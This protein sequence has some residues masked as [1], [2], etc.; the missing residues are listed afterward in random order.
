MRGYAFEVADDVQE[1]ALVSIVSGRPSRRRCR[2]SSSAFLG[3][4]AHQHLFVKQ[5]ARLAFVARHEDSHRHAELPQHALLHLVY[6]RAPFRANRSLFLIL[7][8]ASSRELYVKRVADVL[9]VDG[10]TQDFR[11]PPQVRFLEPIITA[12]LDVMPLTA[13]WR[14]LI[15]SSRAATC[16]ASCGRPTRARPRTPAACL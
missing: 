5:V 10:E 14:R 13:L 7:R 2:W 4:I 12:N 8:A 9:E 15:A 3:A 11:T 1:S 6:L 16:E